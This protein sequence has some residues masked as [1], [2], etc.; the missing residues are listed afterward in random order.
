MAETLALWHPQ[1]RQAL[2]GVL[3]LSGAI[4]YLATALFYDL[5]RDTQRFRAV[6]AGDE[7][8]LELESAGTYRFTIRNPRLD[9]A[10]QFVTV[11]ILDADRQY[12]FGFGDELY[13]ATGFD[14]ERWEEWDDQYQ[15]KYVFPSPGSYYLRLDVE[16]GSLNALRSIAASPTGGDTRF[17]I[18]IAL[19]RVGGSSLPH[20]LGSIPLLLAGL[21][22]GRRALVVGFLALFNLEP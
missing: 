20:T 11:E 12:L 9:R 22:L 3:L 10:W 1:Q 15:I 18:D 16:Q 6:A 19:T 13:H 21:W 14:G 4:L 8:P 2:L 17:A 7:V 5:G